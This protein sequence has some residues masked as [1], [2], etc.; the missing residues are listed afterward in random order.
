MEALIYQTTRHNRTSVKTTDIDNSVVRILRY[1]GN[2]LLHNCAKHFS[3][4]LEKND[5]E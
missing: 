3:L 4:D 1:L 2:G 5:N